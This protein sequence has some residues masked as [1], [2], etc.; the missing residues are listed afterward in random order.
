MKVKGRVRKPTKK[1]KLP[2]YVM[3]GETNPELKTRGTCL[4]LH[5]G[6]YWR[7]GGQWG[8]DYMF[9]GNQLITWCP[10][11]WHP[12]LHKRKLTEVT[13]EVWKE[14]NGQYANWAED[15]TWDDRNEEDFLPF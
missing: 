7:D 9:I 14:D 5:N 1:D 13:K 4:R 8:V 10:G 2:M 11:N 3:M 15:P 12:Q 6:E